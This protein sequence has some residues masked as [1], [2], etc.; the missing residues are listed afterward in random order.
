MATRIGT[1]LASA[2]KQRPA[3]GTLF[4]FLALA[5]AGGAFASGYGAGGEVGRWVVALAAGVLAFW[6]ATMAYRMLR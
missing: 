2:V 6:L 4:A 5:F 1:G 3:L